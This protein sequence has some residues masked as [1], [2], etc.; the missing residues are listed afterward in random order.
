MGMA[1]GHKYVH[2]QPLNHKQKAA[3]G[4][5]QSHPLYSNGGFRGCKCTPLW[6]LV[7]YFCINN[8][9]SPSN[10]YTAV[11]CSNNNQAQL[12]T[13]VSVPYWSPDD[14]LSLELLRDIQ[15][16]RLRDQKWAWQPQNFRLRFARQWLNPPCWISKSATVQDKFW[17]IPGFTSCAGVTRRWRLLS[18]TLNAVR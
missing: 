6:W 12:H 2:K 5:M 11:E 18:H 7:M 8:C 9:T 17:P 15:F 4:A 10:D 16:G 13:H 14:W 3:L 1:H